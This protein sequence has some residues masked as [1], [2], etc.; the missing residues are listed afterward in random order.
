MRRY[1]EKEVSRLLKRAS[2][3]QRASPT[4]PN[5]SGLTLA[6]LEDVAREAGLDVTLLRQ[7]AT[8]LERS[9]LETTV[10]EKLAGGPAH[11]VIE[12][13]LPFEA[14]EASFGG[15]IPSIESAFGIGGQV[16]QVGRTFTWTWGQRNSGRT[17]Q[18]RVTIGRGETHIRVEENYGTMMGGLFGGILGGVGGG[19]GLGAAPAVGM[20]LGSTV[21]AFGLPVLVVGGTYWG[22]RTGF[23]RYVQRRRRALERLAHEIS[24]ALSVNSEAK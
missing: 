16:G 11:I 7:A 5:P 9:P 2:E 24:Q 22:V 1:N 6:E 10:V 3:L 12:L 8:E 21:L 17:G 23:A 20:A 4:A 18:T 14:D 13:T 19:V 15:L